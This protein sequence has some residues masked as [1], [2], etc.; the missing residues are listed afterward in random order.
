MSFQQGLSGL[1]AASRNLDAIGNNVANASTVGF[2]SSGVVFADVYAASIGST[3][4]GGD[5]IGIGTQVAEVRGNFDQGNVSTTNNPLDMAINGQGFFRLDTNGSIT[6]SRNGQFHLDKDGYIVNSSGSK[7][8]GYGVDGLGNI[9]VANPVPLQ[10]SSAQLNATQ[11]SSA[12]I[13]LNLDARDPV[14]SKPFDIKDASTYDKATSITVYDSL[15]NAHALATYYVKTAANKWSV[16][17]AAD[18]AAIAAPLGTMTFKTDGT[19]DTTATTLPFNVSVPL[20]AGPTTPLNFKLDYTGS[21]QYASNFSVDTLWQDGFA[22]GMLSGYGISDDGT[23]LGRYSNGQSRNLGQI[24]LSNFKNPQGLAMLGN[25]AYGESAESGQ[26][27]P[28]VPGGSNFGVIQSGAVEDSNVDL[29]Q[30]LVNMITA[31]RVYQ[32]NAQTI[33]T[34]DQVLNTLVNLR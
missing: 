19:L 4:A 6:Y 22:P 30:E 24:V 12:K 5:A 16:Y 34:Q 25:N 3:G 8:S 17:G 26:P 7:L 1:N 14:I 9:L 29:T 20:A 10:V 32:A 28:G 11:T 23:I 15:G 27:L 31:Q 13:G 2:K 21:T 33:K 18:G